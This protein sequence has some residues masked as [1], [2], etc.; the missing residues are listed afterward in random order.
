MNVSNTC[1]DEI[2]LSRYSMG[3]FPHLAIEEFE[4]HLAGCSACLSK[5]DRLSEQQNAIYQLAQ[6]PPAT[7]PILSTNLDTWQ[8]AETH[9][10]QRKSPEVD[11]FIAEFRVLELLGEGGVGRVYRCRHPRTG[12]DVAIKVLRPEYN[13]H[14]SVNR[15]LAECETLTKLD[16]PHIARMLDSGNAHGEIYLVMELIH[17]DSLVDYCD[18]HRLDVHRRLQLFIDVCLAVQH[19]HQKGLIHRD[20]KPSNVL[21]AEVDGRATP[22]IIDFGIARVSLPQERI[23]EAKVGSLSGTFR[24][25]TEPG[26]L[27]GTP[28]YMS[29]EQAQLDTQSIDTR[30]DIFSLGSMLFELLVGSSP[31]VSPGMP[32]SVLETLH[33]VCNEPTPNLTVRLLQSSDPTSIAT[34]RSNSVFS[35]KRTLAGELQWIINRALEKRPV[36]RYATVGDLAAD[37]ESHLTG[38]PIAASPDSTWYRT[39]KL[40][41][42]NKMLAVVIGLV[43]SLLTTG[44]I[45][46]FLLRGALK[47]E[48]IAKNR[49]EENSLQTREA[50]DRFFLQ[51][52]E[53]EQLQSPSLIEL[54]KNLLTDA[55]EY[56]QQFSQAPVINDQLSAALLTDVATAQARISQILHTLGEYRPAIDMIEKGLNSNHML[57]ER[58]GSKPY[59]VIERAELLLRLASIH[60]LEKRLD[61][62]MR[63]GEQAIEVLRTAA[64]SPQTSLEQVRIQ[65]LLANGLATFGA[66]ARIVAKFEEATLAFTEAIELHR[67]ILENDPLD[68]RHRRNYARCLGDYANLLITTKSIEQAIEIQKEIVLIYEQLIAENP[69]SVLDILGIA[70]THSNLCGAFHNLGQFDRALAEQLLAIEL[71]NRAI[72]LEPL[73]ASYRENLARAYRAIAFIY[74]TQGDDAQAEISLRSQ[75]EELERIVRTVERNQIYQRDLAKAYFE[76]GKFC[77]A[78]D[79]LIA[80]L[81]ALHNSQVLYEQIVTRD[82]GDTY[83]KVYLLNCIRRQLKIAETSQESNNA[84]PLDI[85]V[86][87]DVLRK[88]EAIWSARI[89]VNERDFV[90][91]KQMV[92]MED[93]FYRALFVK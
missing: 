85:Q 35:L 68:T 4:E 3:E 19:A 50:V 27:V 40:L 74:A 32:S 30:S 23:G 80:A 28:Q 88:D 52:A 20:L 43:F 83:A 69:K 47:R 72:E 22:K 5:L 71:F 75:V 18:R 31:F 15:F 44:S 84:S 61:E 54:R 56:Y 24:P 45:G 90:S 73:T 77:A 81:T 76:L 38:K 41:A 2:E 8:N 91:K 1:P 39:S 78:R 25:V 49:A 21:V 65:S 42:R 58:L 63:S 33:R 89:D 17:G 6:L 7:Q 16:H 59:L 36:N 62:A 67:R 93:Q 70:R 79:Q 55:L 14:A 26:M 10:A 29:P 51:V 60:K 92:D 82:Q 64:S 87:L 53:N 48:S 34:A 46:F 9:A 57:I 12:Q 37:I 13:S 66:T 11:D 86:D